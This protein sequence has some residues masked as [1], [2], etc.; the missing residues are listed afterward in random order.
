MLLERHHEQPEMP[1][2]KNQNKTKKLFKICLVGVTNVSFFSSRFS[3]LVKQ[4]NWHKTDQQ[5]KNKQNHAEDSKG[6][7]AIEAYV[8]TRAK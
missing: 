2:K 6:S 4:L 7:Q 3:W 1:K 8:M 5:K